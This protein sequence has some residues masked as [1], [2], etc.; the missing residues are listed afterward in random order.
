LVE[1]LMPSDRE[2]ELRALLVLDQIPGV[3]LKTL[4]AL[5][6]RFSSGRA[7]LAASMQA[8]SKIA[9]RAAALARGDAEIRERV[10]VALSDAERLNAPALT[11]SDPEYPGML[12]NLADPLS[13]PAR[14]SRSSAR[15]RL[16]LGLATSL[17]SWRPPSR[18]RVTRS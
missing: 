11:W 13:C 4:A 3:G 1:F 15:A 9:G 18:V 6:A 16:R 5:V 7:S 17:D 10:R 2:A 14:V 8:F 12:H